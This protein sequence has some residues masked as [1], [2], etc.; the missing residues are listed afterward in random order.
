MFQIMT[1]LL[2]THVKIKIL[3][4]TF[5]EYN[6]E[7]LSRNARPTCEIANAASVFLEMT[8]QL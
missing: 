4:N 6:N 7:T 8:N 2:L 5:A 3:E 1:F